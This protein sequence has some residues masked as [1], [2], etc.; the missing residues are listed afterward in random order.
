MSEEMSEK[1]VIIKYQYSEAS[2]RAIKKYM[3]AHKEVYNQRAHNYYLHHK[4]NEEFKAK[5]NER[6]KVQREKLKQ[7]KLSDPE[8]VKKMKERNRSNYLKRKN[9]K[10]ETV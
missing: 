7:R 6:A 10:N 4:D 2:K 8:Y 5:L 1:V 3:D 9:L